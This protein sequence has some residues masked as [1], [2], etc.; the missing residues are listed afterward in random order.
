MSKAAQ[1]IKSLNLLD[2]NESMKKFKEVF[3]DIIHTLRDNDIDYCIIGAIAYGQYLNPRSTSDID[4]LV[5]EEDS[6]KLMK[7]L[8]KFNPRKEDDSHYK[9]PV[10]KESGIN[11]VEILFTVGATPDGVAINTAQPMQIFGVKN[12]YVCRPEPLV[13]MYLQSASGG[14]EKSFIDAK[15]FLKQKKVNLSKLR[16]ILEDSWDNSLME[17][18]NYAIAGKSITGESVTSRSWS[19]LQKQKSEWMK[20]GR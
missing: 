13:A 20:R 2:S 7:L 3:S 9:I 14:N 19:D 15:E 18:Y 8:S 4:F 12:V 5:F 17:Y 10:I 1:L 16:N 11:L 6:N